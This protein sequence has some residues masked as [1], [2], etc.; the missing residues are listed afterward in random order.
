MSHDYGPHSNGGTAAM[1][2]AARAKAVIERLGKPGAYYPDRRRVIE[3]AIS[4]AVEAERERCAQIAKARAAFW[5]KNG[6]EIAAA[7][8]REIE[9]RIRSG[10]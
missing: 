6:D 5:G 2:I 3:A 4:S 1:T 9:A 10:E 7:S 8:G